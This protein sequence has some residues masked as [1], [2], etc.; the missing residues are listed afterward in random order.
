MKFFT[1][2]FVL[3]AVFAF[4]ANA[5]FGIGSLP[6]LGDPLNLV[7]NVLGSLGLNSAQIQEAPA[8][9][10]DDQTLDEDNSGDDLVSTLEEENPDDLDE[11]RDILN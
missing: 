3:I 9:D 8:Q 4:H 10:G 1:F 2:F 5:T 7:G 6:G 11:W